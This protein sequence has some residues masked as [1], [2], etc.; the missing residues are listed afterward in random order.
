MPHCSPFCDTP[1]ASADVTDATNVTAA[2]AAMLSGAT[3]T[4]N[5]A[6]QGSSGATLSLT[7]TDTTGADTELLVKEIEE[8]AELL[9]RHL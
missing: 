8:S 5:V 7:S 1:L 6:V 3:F 4:G 2:G 9:R